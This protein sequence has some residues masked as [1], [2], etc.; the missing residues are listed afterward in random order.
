MSGRPIDRRR[1]LAGTA[2]ALAGALGTGALSGCSRGAHV[3]EPPTT[4]RELPSRVPFDRV[5]PP[6]IEGS[7][8]GI[9][10]PAYFRYPRSLSTSVLEA[11]GRGGDISALCLTFSP[12]APGM[13]TNRAW[14]AINERLNARLKLMTTTYTDYSA[15]FGALLAS[16]DLPDIVYLHDTKT[17]PRQTDVLGR[18]FADL[19]PLLEGRGVHRYPNLANLPTYMWRNAL[20]NRV[21]HGVPNARGGYWWLWQLA[22]GAHLREL[23]GV[24]PRS[25]EEL[26]S[27]LKEATGGGRYG[28]IGD[29]AFPPGLVFAAMMWRA[30]KNWRESQGRFVKDVETEEFRAAVEYCRFLWSAGLIY[31]SF[32]TQAQALDM[33]YNGLGTLYTLTVGSTK[34]SWEFLVQNKPEFELDVLTPFGHDGHAGVYHFTPGSYGKVVLRKA[35]RERLEELLGVLNFLAA[36]FGTHEQHLLTYGVEGVDHEWDETGTP[37]LTRRGRAELNLPFAFLMSGPD[38]LYSRARSRDFAAN[39]HRW[40]S[41]HAAIA[42]TDPTIGLSAPTMSARGA[43]LEQA[44]RDELRDIIVGR[45]PLSAYDDMVARWRKLGGDAMRAEYEEAY[46]RAHV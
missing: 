36:P 38:A 24:K 43:L 16:G 2:G 18:L 7:A 10:P 12:P 35:S 46:E 34:A 28:I 5:P 20:F 17:I 14:Q 41:E 29:H 23:G 33:F 32:P 27:F 25:A 11:P 4:I 9:V 31:P 8:D 13:R 15:K 26:T 22:N 42:V 44:L 3:F 39:M 45:L 30:P 1:F 19:G 6:D 21:L 37:Q 40:M